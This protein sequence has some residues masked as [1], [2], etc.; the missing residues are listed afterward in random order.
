MSV[1]SVVLGLEPVCDPDCMMTLIYDSA[2]SKLP[3][4]LLGLIDEEMVIDHDTL[5]M[6]NG[7]SKRITRKSSEGALDDGGSDS[8][9]GQNDSSGQS[10]WSSAVLFQSTG[11]VVRSGS[12][13]KVSRE[14]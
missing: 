3:V 8:G 11:V 1:F 12:R 2:L 5:A 10:S 13:Q 6:I 14:N 4:E 9:A 7:R